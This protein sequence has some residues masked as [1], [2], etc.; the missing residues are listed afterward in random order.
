M[1]MEGRKIPCI[2][3]FFVILK[4][5]IGKWIRR[6][7]Y[8]WVYVRFI[9]VHSWQ[10]PVSILQFTKQ[11]FPQFFLHKNCPP[12]LVPSRVRSPSI[13]C[14][15]SYF[16]SFISCFGYISQT[17]LNEYKLL[18]S[19]IYPR[20]D[21]SFSNKQLLLWAAAVPS[22]RLSFR[23]IIVKTMRDLNFWACTKQLKYRTHRTPVRTNVRVNGKFSDFKSPFTFLAG[24]T[25]NLD[26][27]ET[28]RPTTPLGIIALL[29]VSL[30]NFEKRF[31]Q[32]SP[33]FCLIPLT[34]E[35]S[36]REVYQDFQASLVQCQGLLRPQLPAYTCRLY[37][38]SLESVGWSQMHN[39]F[40]ARFQKLGFAAIGW[41]TKQILRSKNISI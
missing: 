8:V 15:P 7:M 9:L 34:N 16:C 2:A 29:S 22:C 4:S 12:V 19:L 13:L 28:A 21:S 25:P 31:L 38:H 20:A 10:I 32:R 14:F 6:Y 30:L 27:Y 5:I 1:M 24:C 36:H 3:Q 17:H 11:L 41:L 39:S 35:G 33:S 37:Q 26:D 40:R 23:R 18:A